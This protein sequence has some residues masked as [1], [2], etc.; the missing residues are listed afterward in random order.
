M[1]YAVIS[2]IH[3]NL[4]ALGSVVAEIDRSGIEDIICLGDI[5]GYGADPNACVEMVRERNIV[6]VMGNH[7]AAA[8]GACEPTHFN[9]AAREAVLWTRKELTDENSEFLRDLPDREVIDN[10]LAVHGAISDPDKY[11]M[12]T[13][14]AE[15]EFPLMDK[16]NICFF[17]HT[18]VG[19]C[20]VFENKNVREIICSELEFTEGM[21]YMINPGSVGQP[22]DRDPRASFLLYDNEGRAHYRRVEYDIERAQEKII[23]KGLNKILAERLSYGF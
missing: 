9:P 10:S 22:R 18:H 21:K 6:S 20:Y 11:I 16:Y 1:K 3:A 14:D 17:G 13:H 8:C 7:D 4:E 19:V 15:P 5:V 23:D 2:D 12:S